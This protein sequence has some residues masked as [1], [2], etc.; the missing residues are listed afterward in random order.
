[1]TAVKTPRH[2]RRSSG[3]TES[4]QRANDTYPPIQR[5]RKRNYQIPPRLARLLVLIGWRVG[6]VEIRR[7]LHCAHRN[8]PRAKLDQYALKSVSQE[9]SCQFRSNRTGLKTGSAV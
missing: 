4:P 1:M 6:G 3:L 8:S 2:T 7:V 9:C 5:R